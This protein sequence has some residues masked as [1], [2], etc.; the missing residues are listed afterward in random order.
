MNQRYP[1]RSLP[2][3]LPQKDPGAP[4]LL[5][6]ARRIRE[7]QGAERLREFIAAMRPFAAP[8]ELKRLAE[9]FGVDYDSLPKREE[10][11]SAHREQGRPGNDP[12]KLISDIMRISGAMQSG[13]DIGKLIG[14]LSGRP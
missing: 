5:A 4:P 10:D 1:T 14:L 9:D 7:E 12:M 13:G 3:R 2:Q 6:L 8:N 11:R